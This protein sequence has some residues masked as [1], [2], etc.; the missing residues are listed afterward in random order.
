MYLS[1]FGDPTGG[2][3]GLSYVKLP[4]KTSR[5]EK[6]D[7]KNQANKSSQVTGTDA[8]LRKLP[9]KEVEEMII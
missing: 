5:Y 3:G 9:M 2:H 8:D 6:D 1:G 4:L 7:K